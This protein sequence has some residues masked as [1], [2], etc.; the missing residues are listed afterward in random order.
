MISFIHRCSFLTW[1]D[2]L[3][4]FLP[5][6]RPSWFIFL[7]RVVGVDESTTPEWDFMELSRRPLPYAKKSPM[8]RNGILWSYQD[9][10]Y[11]SS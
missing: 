7:S 11:S 4:Y 8:L 6:Y 3:H 2:P 9:L 1:N 5:S 10:L